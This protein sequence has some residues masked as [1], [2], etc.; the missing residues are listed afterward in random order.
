MATDTVSGRAD[1]IVNMAYGGFTG[2]GTATTVS[3]GF[4]PNH[5]I[6]VNETDAIRWE[7][8]SG[9]AAAN[10]VKTVTAG[11]TTVDTGSA[12]TWADGI[13]TLSATLAA[14]A[15]VIAWYASK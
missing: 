9:M 8:I 13:L 7:K 2:D 1:G 12:I 14:S 5:V 10:S 3:L 4:N 11:T 15:K 6:V